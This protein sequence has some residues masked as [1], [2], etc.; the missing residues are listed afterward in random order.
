[1]HAAFPRLTRLEFKIVGGLHS[2][3]RSLERWVPLGRTSPTCDSMEHLGIAVRC[4]RAVS[5]CGVA[6]RCRRAVSPC[7]V[8][9]RCRR[10]VSPC[11]VAVRCRR[12][13]SPCGVAVRC[14]RAVSPCGVAV[15]CRRAVSPCGVAVRCRRAVSPCGVAVRVAVRCRRAVSPCGVAVRCRRAVSPCG[16]AVRCRRAVSPCGVAVRCRRAVSPCGVAVRC[17]RA[18]SPCGVAVRCRRAVSLC[19]VAVRCRRAVAV[20]PALSRLGIAGFDAA[21][22]CPVVTPHIPTLLGLTGSGCPTCAAAGG[23]PHGRLLLTP[24]RQSPACGSLTAAWRAAAWTAFADALTPLTCLREVHLGV[25]TDPDTEPEFMPRLLRTLAGTPHRSMLHLTSGYDNPF[26]G[27]G[28]YSIKARGSVYAEGLRH[29][30]GL[31]TLH[32]EGR[33]IFTE[34]EQLCVRTLAIRCLPVD[35]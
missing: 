25:H 18:V 3:H 4:R 32:L 22:L 21:A 9:V 8:A 27:P 10:A 24:S 7:G 19:G 26:D 17:R 35:C 23:P 15:R 30:K 16:V 31:Q 11:G 29:L 2:I 13:V 6:V 12:A 14:R 28:A 33:F 5:P 20:C 1:M 34:V